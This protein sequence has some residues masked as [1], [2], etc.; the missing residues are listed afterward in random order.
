M[1]GLRKACLRQGLLCSRILGQAPRGMPASRLA[2]PQ[3]T[4][5]VASYI[6]ELP[7][8]GKPAFGRAYFSRAISWR[9]AHAA[10]DEAEPTA[11][12]LSFAARLAQGECRRHPG[13]E[14]ASILQ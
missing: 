14:N 2:F 6:E 1:R 11:P 9:E 12:P 3:A 10:V 13:R 5:R 7:Y 4:R 8:V